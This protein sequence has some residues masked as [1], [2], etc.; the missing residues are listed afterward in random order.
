MLN[1]GARGKRKGINE[2]KGWNVQLPEL[3]MWE[4]KLN[5]ELEI[6]VSIFQT[7]WWCSQQEKSCPPSL[8]RNWTRLTVCFLFGFFKV[9]S[10]IE[11]LPRQQRKGTMKVKLE[12]FAQKKQDLVS[13]GDNVPVDYQKPDSLPPNDLDL[14][15][16]KRGPIN[17][18][19]GMHPL[20]YRFLFV[21]TRICSQTIGGSGA[22]YEKYHSPKPERNL[23]QGAWMPQQETAAH[24]R[25]VCCF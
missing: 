6:K 18:T 22:S 10:D 16:Q 21:G 15:N 25:Q 20:C 19:K 12:E 8:S 23:W 7:V 5:R 2:R 24:E 3:R 1:E 13:S 4:N 14:C 11:K 17:C 9:K